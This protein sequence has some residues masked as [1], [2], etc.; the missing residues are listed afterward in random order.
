MAMTGN[1]QE[2]QRVK[3]PNRLSTNVSFKP[4]YLLFLCFFPTVELKNETTCSIC[5][6]YDTCLNDYVN[7]SQYNGLV[8]ASTKKRLWGGRS[9][10]WELQSKPLTNI[11]VISQKFCFKDRKQVRVPTVC[12]LGVINRPI[13][14]K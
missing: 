7:R 12:D 1:N 11:G 2:H 14:V 10:I 5:L 6:K 3:M 4:I 9:D 8:V 13:G